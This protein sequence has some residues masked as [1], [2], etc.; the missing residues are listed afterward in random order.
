MTTDQVVAALAAEGYDRHRVRALI[1]SFA[2][3]HWRQSEAWNDQEV[4][5]LRRQ[6]GTPENAPDLSFD[7][8]AWAADLGYIVW[9]TTGG[10]AT[11]ASG[12]LRRI[13]G[14]LLRQPPDGDWMPEATKARLNEHGEVP[15]L[16]EPVFT[17]DRWAPDLGEAV[18]RGTGGQLELSEPELRVA[19][20]LLL[21][22]CE[23]DWVPQAARIRR[24]YEPGL[25]RHY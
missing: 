23:G 8:D 5:V 15:D 4:N 1:D 13:A 21:H 17:I 12:Q 18:N 25:R 9:R 24:D 22:G 7:L 3:V 14:E 10:R 19:A 6:L 2:D 16:F 20:N 11:L